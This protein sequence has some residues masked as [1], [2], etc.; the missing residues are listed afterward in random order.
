MKK[1]LILILLL[2]FTIIPFSQ[3]QN[4]A[5]N[6]LFDDAQ[7]N[8]NQTNIFQNITI[9][10]TDLQLN[11]LTDV[12]VP[13]P[14]DG[15]S[16]VWDNSLMKWVAEFVISRWDIDLSNGYLYNNSDTLFFNETKLNNTIDAR[17]ASVETDFN[18]Y[19]NGSSY[20]NINYNITAGDADD[21]EF[22]IIPGNKFIFGNT[23]T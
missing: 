20:N 15:Q 22:V 1:T 10:A 9:N 2:L 8:I 4:F 7:I 17:A 14:S 5:Y 6:R 13:S 19:I 21:V 23:F 11:N 18:T 12:Q 16:L 3:A